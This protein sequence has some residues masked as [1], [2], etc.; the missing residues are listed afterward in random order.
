MNFV[1]MSRSLSSFL[2]IRLVIWGGPSLTASVGKGLGLRRPKGTEG[3]AVD[4][5]V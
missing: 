3:W 4:L 2:S 1:Q 5:W